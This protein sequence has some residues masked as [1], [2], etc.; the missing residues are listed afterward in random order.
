MAT[1]LRSWS[2]TSVIT[3]TTISPLSE[4]D[5]ITDNPTPPPSVTYPGTL[6]HCAWIS[7][8]IRRQMRHDVCGQGLGLGPASERWN[9]QLMTKTEGA[10]IT[11]DFINLIVTCQRAAE[12]LGS[13]PCVNVCA[14]PIMLPNII[15]LILEQI[16]LGS[17]KTKGP[18]HFAAV[19]PCM[20]TFWNDKNYL[21]FYYLKVV[22]WQRE[23]RN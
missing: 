22:D 15:S 4:L 8:A 17:E 12:R 3:T 16:P 5:I 6:F 9:F 14:A 13:W 20:Q 1:A 7:V 23:Q 11:V 19:K 10:T 21:G 18:Y 2:S